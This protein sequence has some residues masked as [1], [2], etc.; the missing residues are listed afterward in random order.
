M[1]SKVCMPMT[2]CALRYPELRQLR[3]VARLLI[4]VSWKRL[5]ELIRALQ[6]PIVLQGSCFCLP[7]GFITDGEFHCF[8]SSTIAVAR[9]QVPF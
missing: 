6:N 4:S 1:D 2:W 8:S 7:E 5:A 9:A 3:Q